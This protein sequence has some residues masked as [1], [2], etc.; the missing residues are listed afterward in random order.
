[1]E[2]APSPRELATIVVKV[3]EWRRLWSS[4]TAK[5]ISV[6][7][8]LAVI[9][10]KLDL[11]NVILFSLELGYL[12][13]QMLMYNQWQFALSTVMSSED[14]GGLQRIASTRN[15]RVGRRFARE[16]MLW[17]LGY[18][19][20]SW[21]FTD[22]LFKS[23]LVS[24]CLYNVVYIFTPQFSNTSLILLSGYLIRYFLKMCFMQITNETKV[25]FTAICRRCRDIH[26]KALTECQW[27][28]PVSETPPENSRE[29]LPPDETPQKS[30]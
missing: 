19:M 12:T 9:Y 8:S 30:R 16:D 29:C 22:S 11:K 27:A 21:N 18:L 20:K 24:I 28:Q 26:S 1:M 4:P 13:L 25:F 14:F 3:V 23:D 6:A 17:T 2:N 10:Q 7:I 15:T 5:V